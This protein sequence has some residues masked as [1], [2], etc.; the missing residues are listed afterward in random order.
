MNQGEV[1]EEKTKACERGDYVKLQQL[2]SDYED[3]NLSPCD[4]YG[5]TLVH[6]AS[7]LGHEECLRILLERN[8]SHQVQNSNLST[9]L[10]LA[11]KFNKETCAR[12]LLEDGANACVRDDSG[13]SPLHYAAASGSPVIV[14]LLLKEISSNPFY[15]TEMEIDALN[16]TDKDACDR[17]ENTPLHFAAK[18]G[19]HECVRNLIEVGA[20][21]CEKNESLNT[22]LHYAAEI[23]S[24]ESIKELLDNISLSGGRVAQLVEQLARDWKN[25]PEVYLA[26][27]KI[28][29]RIFLGGKRRSERGAD[30]T[31][32]F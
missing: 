1:D 30:H 13:N 18:S 10:H 11:A 24:A 20:N 17:H 27:Y 5:N 2:L 9:P 4:R 29:Y 6:V 14:E 7:K 12:M 22:P 16:A 15:N 3:V 25:G 23:G 19:S 28:E 31:T 8:A 32:S 26:S 21:M